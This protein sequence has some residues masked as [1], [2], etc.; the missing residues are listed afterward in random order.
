MHPEIQIRHEAK[1]GCGFRSKT[2]S[3]YLI[4]GELALPCGKLPIPLTVCPCCGNGFKPSRGWTWVDA[5]RLAKAGAK[6]K[7]CGLPFCDKCPVMAMVLGN[8]QEAGLLWIGEKFYKTPS[9]FV[10]EVGSMGVC[11]RIPFVPNNFELGKTW[12]LLAHRK[13]ITKYTFGDTEPGYIPGIFQVFKPTAVEVLCD[14]TESDEVVEGY[15]KRGLTP[16]LV[17]H[18]KQEAEPL[19]FEELK[20]EEIKSDALGG[21]DG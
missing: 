8:I 18:K 21:A 20:K 4:S 9:D 7:E 5:A 1:R 16:V 13:A 15:L 3:L 2:G 12:V 14:G 17:K 6:D 19:D 10:R 11:R